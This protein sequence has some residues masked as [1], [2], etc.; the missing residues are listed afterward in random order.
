M[1]SQFLFN[2]YSIPIHFLLISYSSPIDF[3]FNS[4]VF[5]I[6]FLFIL[7]PFISKVFQKSD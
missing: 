5:P 4:D 3:L 2:S 6:H 7:I 1:A